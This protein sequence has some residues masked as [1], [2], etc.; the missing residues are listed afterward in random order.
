MI[1][2]RGYRLG[3]ADWL[4]FSLIQILINPMSV[5]SLHDT[6]HQRNL[7]KYRYRHIGCPVL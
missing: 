4:F 5:A 2:D 1:G 3:V 6:S 7:S